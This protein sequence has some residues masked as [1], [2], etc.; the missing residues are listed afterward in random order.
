MTI[1]EHTMQVT[2]QAAYPV[3][4]FLL[5]ILELQHDFRNKTF[6]NLPQRIHQLA[7]ACDS[8]QRHN[9]TGEEIGEN[10]IY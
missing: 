4:S 1:L 8:I 10:G 3:L 6:D 2:D 9:L 7:K 5:V